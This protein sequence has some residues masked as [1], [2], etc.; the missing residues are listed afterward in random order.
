MKRFYAFLPILV[1]LVW[2]MPSSAKAAIPNI[3]TTKLPNPGGGLFTNPNPDT[4]LKFP[5]LITS[6]TSGDFLNDAFRFVLDILTTFGGVIALGYI[7]YG[8]VKFI[9]SAGDPARAE[10][11]KKSIIGAIV[12]I[13]IV[14]LAYIVTLYV[15]D[16]IAGQS[17]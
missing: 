5:N 16:L 8:G 10:E 4:A 3:T 15:R 17:T 11:G 9:T 6:F 1:W 2:H 7:I 13:V 14:A 12:G